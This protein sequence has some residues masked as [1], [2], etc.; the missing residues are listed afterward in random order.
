MLFSV[1]PLLLLTL[2]IVFNFHHFDYCVY[3]CVPSWVHPAWNTLVFLDLVDYFLSK[4]LE[5]F[6]AIMSSNIFLG[7]FSLPLILGS[8]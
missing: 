3:Q 2:I 6:L 1:F 5:K 8:L 4:M 7:P